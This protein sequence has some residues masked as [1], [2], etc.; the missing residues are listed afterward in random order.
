MRVLNEN[1]GYITLKYLILFTLGGSVYCICEILFR[2]FSHY[3]MFLAGGFVLS[4]IYS[5]AVDFPYTPY[6]LKCFVGAVIITCTELGIGIAVNDLFNWKVWDYSDEI[7][8]LYG[9]ICVKFFVLWFFV[10]A[11][12]YPLA[13]C[14]KSVFERE[15]SVLNRRV[16]RKS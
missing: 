10:S 8:N 2:G 15:K 1:N 3:S 4:A 14:F 11:L 6:I 5:F 7:L 9:Q 13:E 12:I 16:F